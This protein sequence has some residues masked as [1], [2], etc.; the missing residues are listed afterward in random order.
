MTTSTSSPTASRKASS[1]ALRTAVPVGLFGLYTS[2]MRVRS[3]TAAA[4][5]GRSCPWPGVLGTWTL[6][7]PVVA[8]MIGYASNDRHE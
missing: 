1:S 5:A 7:A 8:V 4:I 2:T 6:V 3:V